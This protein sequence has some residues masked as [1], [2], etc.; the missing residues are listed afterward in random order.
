[1]FLILI[2]L[3]GLLVIQL[4]Y[5]LAGIP[6]ISILGINVL[7]DKL[8]GAVVLS[9]TWTYLLVLLVRYYQVNVVVEN[10]YDYLHRL[11]EQLSA[12]LGDEK[13][14]RRES[15]AYLVKKAQGFRTWIWRFYTIAIPIMVIAA[16]A[17][18]AYLEWYAA[19]IPL[20]HKIYDATALGASL[21]LI[22]LYFLRYG[23]PKLQVSFPAL[24]D[25]TTSS[26][27]AVA[28]IAKQTSAPPVID[29]K[30][31]EAFIDK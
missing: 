6:E 29:R 5:N 23:V 4:Q 9:A 19:S 17:R 13:L 22:T 26:P 7:L 27:Q 16:T 28:S 2:S 8:P 21:W 30:A 25:N 20:Y 3:L 1:M 31:D 10:Q 18:A 15:A 14:Y 24:E 12:L 11:E